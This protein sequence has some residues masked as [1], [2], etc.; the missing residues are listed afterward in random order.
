MSSSSEHKSTV[1][2]IP[3]RNRADIAKNAIRSVLDQPGS[4]V[5]VMVSDNSTAPAELKELEE[6]CARLDDPRLHYVRPP[7]QL[8]MS[9]HWE[10]AIGQA[11]ESYDAS[12][13]I[14]LTDR[15]M[16]K[17]LAL[18][19]VLDIAAAYTDKIVSYNHDRIVDD[20]RPILIE[21][22]P[23]TGKLLAVETLRLSYLYSQSVFLPTL[24]RMLNCVVPRG[25]FERMR[26]RFGNVFASIAPD[27]LF[28]CRCLE[29]EDSILFYDKSPIFHYA[30]DRSQG[31]SVTRG[32][33]TPANADFSANLPADKPVRNYA[34][35]IPQLVTTTNAIINEYLIFK[36]ETKSPRFFEVDLQNYL[37]KNAEEINEVM[38]PQL[39]AELRALL[40]AHGLEGASNGVSAGRSGRATV[41]K[42][43]SPRAVLNKVW[44]VAG[45]DVL[46]PFWLLLARRFGVPPPNNPRFEFEQLED[47][48]S[49]MREFQPRPVRS[50]S[51]HEELEPRE[52]AR[53]APHA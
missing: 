36:R 20:R 33:I 10:W 50:L 53:V 47:A 29:M 41:R 4:D 19:E 44:G 12:H 1:V 8:S 22:C 17:R 13:F 14:Y 42:L 2:V 49:Y 46:K 27:L 3:T 11:L 9:A 45:D 37:R 30:L 32:E 28:C 24:P 34:A 15:M 23:Y 26:Q 31:A 38:D 39:K 25:V 6:Y 7:G 43:H 18:K 16:F 21:Q 5:R 51:W 35:P 40:E 48:I 52:L